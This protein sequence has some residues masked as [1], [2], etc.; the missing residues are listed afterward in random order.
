MGMHP[1]LLTPKWMRGRMPD[2]DKPKGPQNLSSALQVESCTPAQAG[3]EEGRIILQHHHS[4]SPLLSVLSTQGVP[5]R[6]HLFRLYSTGH[7]PLSIPT[8]PLQ[9][10]FNPHTCSNIPTSALCTAPAIPRVTRSTTS[11]GTQKTP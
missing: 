1:H 10:S 7:V 4:Q 6:K 2:G 3:T 5:P 11:I 9:P 8:V